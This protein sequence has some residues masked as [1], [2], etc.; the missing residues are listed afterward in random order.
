MSRSVGTMVKRET[1]AKETQDLLSSRV[2]DAYNLANT[3]KSAYTYDNT[4]DP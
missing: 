4:R 2:C 3:G 1:T